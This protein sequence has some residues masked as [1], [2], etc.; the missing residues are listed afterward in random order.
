MGQGLELSHDMLQRFHERAAG[1][2]RDNRFF[3]ED[4]DELKEAGYYLMTVPEELGGRGMR[5]NEVARVTLAKNGDPAILEV[6]SSQR[7]IQEGD[8]VLPVD[9]YQWDA[10]FMPHPM[11]PMPEDMRVMAVEGGNYGVGQLQMVSISGGANQGL[12]AGHVFSAFTPGE[13]IRDDVKYP[14]GTMADMMTW[15]GD[16]VTLPDEYNAHIMVIRVF[17]EVSY[18]MVMNGARVVHEFDTLRH[19][20]ETL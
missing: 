11:E 3:Q 8:L 17:D 5:L 19:P 18:A 13:R 2:D 14:Q 10:Q 7:E 12:E 6:M 9:D 20:D 4:F 16:K 15:D 1:Y